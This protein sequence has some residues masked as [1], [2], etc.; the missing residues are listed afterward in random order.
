MKVKLFKHDWSVR[1]KNCYH[2]FALCHAIS[3]V[4]LLF[5]GLNAF[6]KDSA[7]LLV[8]WERSGKKPDVCA[9]SH[10]AKGT[11]DASVAKGATVGTDAETNETDILD[12]DEEEDDD[13]EKAEEE[14]VVAS[15]A[16]NGK[17][18]TNRDAA[19]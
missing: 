11:K 14:A 6:T 15:S 1:C 8:T 17:V 13:D 16:K 3:L 7:K 12:S 4:Q 2:A 18:F 19:V 10:D 5:E 9:Y